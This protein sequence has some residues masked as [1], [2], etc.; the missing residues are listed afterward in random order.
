MFH[1]QPGDVIVLDDRSD[2]A[3]GF[4]GEMLMSYFQAQGGAGV[5][6]DAGI[7][8]SVPIFQNLKVPCGLPR[9][10]PARPDT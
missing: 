9:S 10:T 2:L 4:F 8:D 5:V 7:R 1:V 3:T 6:M